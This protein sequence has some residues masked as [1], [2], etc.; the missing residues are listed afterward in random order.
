MKKIILL[1]L[2]ICLVFI[3]SCNDKTPE[4]KIEIDIIE[5]S[6]KEVYYTDEFNIT[7][8]KI[9]V[10]KNEET[11]EESLTPLLIEN[12][13]SEFKEGEYIFKVNYE[14]AKLEFSVNFIERE[15]YTEGLEFVLNKTQDA[16]LVS[17]YLGSDK[18][19]IIP[20]TFNYL[21]VVGIKS[22]AFNNNQVIEKVTLPET[23][24]E[25]EANAFSSSSIKE[26][27]IPESVKKIGAAAFYFCDNLRSVIIPKTVKT[28]EEYAFYNTILVYTNCSDVS[29]WDENAFDDN[30]VYIYKDLDLT[31]II[32]DDYFEYY[33]D[34][35]ATLLNYIG[36]ESNIEIPTKVN[37]YQV[38]KIGNSAFL[39]LDTLE[40]IT[41]S[42]SIIYIGDKA[43]RE[44][45]LTTVEIPSSVKEIGIYA[46][47]ACE[48]LEE[49]IFN[50][51]LE[52][53]KMSAF[54]ACANLKVAILPNSLHTIEQYGFQNCLRIEKVF[55][56][57]S[58]TYVGDYAFYACHK[59]ML[60]I[61][62]EN[63]P[64]TWHSNFSPSGAKKTFNASRENIK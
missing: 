15:F 41:I 3:A 36:E 52:I 33:I 22:Y 39:Q 23:I 4:T 27:N 6:I 40:E 35:T 46:F 13:P 28:I 45:S 11:K 1:L 37:N 18:N 7:T 64:S 31:K 38:E 16:Y 10:T 9:S 5:S 56:P 60:Y 57:K 43:F 17:K 24:S 8:I 2:V 44:T 14:G 50:E 32:K 51:G 47:S 12:Y 25:I 55:I 63:I 34:N 20:E 26:I 30:L 48:S 59:A 29:I 42:D 19:V 53:I 49:V 54:A 21:N 58:V 61:E 62:A